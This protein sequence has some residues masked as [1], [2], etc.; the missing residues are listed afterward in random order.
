MGVV[1]DVFDI[2]E[3]ALQLVRKRQER[4]RVDRVLSVMTRDK[5][6]NRTDVAKLAK[7]SDDHTLQALRALKDAD[8]VISIDVNEEPDGTFSRRI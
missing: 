8:K 4:S 7:V 2:G 3:R 6:W 5:N 1:K